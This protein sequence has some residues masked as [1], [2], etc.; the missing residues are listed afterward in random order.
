MYS[1]AFTNVAHN[2]W[3]ERSMCLWTFDT[4]ADDHSPY[5]ESCAKSPNSLAKWWLHQ[6]YDNWGNTG[7][8]LWVLQSQGTS[9]TSCLEAH[10]NASLSFNLSLGTCNWA[11]G[12]NDMNKQWEALKQTNGSWV[13][14][15]VGAKVYNKQ[16]C[17]GAFGENQIAVLLQA[18]NFG[19]TQQWNAGNAT[20]VS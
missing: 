10:P 5:L 20:P 16:L 7:N 6:K 18:C 1:R 19:A 11:D 2:K 17:I 3:E 8:P 15:S 14:R 13:I 12:G 9:S 4:R